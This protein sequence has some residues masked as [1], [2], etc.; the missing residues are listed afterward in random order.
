MSKTKKP[1]SGVPIADII[2]GV[3]KVGVNI[4]DASKRRQ[5]DFSFN[6]QQLQAQLGLAEKAAQ[7]QAEIARMTALAQAAGGKASP[8]KDNTP[9][10]IGLGVIVAMVFGTVIYIAVK[11]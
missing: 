1:T 10:I 11:K 2:E 7:S 9:L 8:E 4:L 3:G 6:Q 5:M